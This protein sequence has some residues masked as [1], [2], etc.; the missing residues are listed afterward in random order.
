MD[1]ARSPRRDRIL[2]GAV[3]ALEEAGYR[4]V[5][6]ERQGEMSRLLLRG[7]A[8]TPLPSSTEVHL[9]HVYAP[10]NPHLELAAPDHIVSW[11]YPTGRP[12]APADVVAAFCTAAPRPS[13][14]PATE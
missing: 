7:R 2:R 5:A 14:A 11:Y 8:S 4:L 12:P 1:R 6:R 10:D 13:D 9:T 3:A